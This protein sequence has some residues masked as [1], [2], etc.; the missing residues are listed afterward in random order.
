MKCFIL[1]L[2]TTCSLAAMAKPYRVVFIC[3][4][5]DGKVLNGLVTFPSEISDWQTRR[6]LAIPMCELSPKEPI[7]VEFL[8]GN[9]RTTFQ[10][11]SNSETVFFFSPEVEKSCSES[12]HD[13][14]IEMTALP[15]SNIRL[16]KDSVGFEATLGEIANLG[17]H[18]SKPYSISI[19]NQIECSIEY[20]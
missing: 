13:F 1:I 7:K 6:S 10:N 8:D 12:F 3:N 14:S 2:L 11:E 16:L 4:L 15:G 17:S 5:F 18:L 20:K 19:N 9:I